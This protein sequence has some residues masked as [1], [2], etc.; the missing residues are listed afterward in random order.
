MCRSVHAMKDMKVTHLCSVSQEWWS[1]IRRSRKTSAVATLVDQMQNASTKN[2]DASPNIKETHTKD[3]DQNA[4]RMPSAAE[5]KPACV[6]NAWIHASEHAETTHFA[7]SSITFQFAHAQLVSQAIHSQ[8]AVLLIL[9]QYPK[10][11]F[12]IHRHVE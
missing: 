5:T 12:A 2:A 9:H 7:K 6:A 4:P 1:K 8:T 11:M 3:A 10:W